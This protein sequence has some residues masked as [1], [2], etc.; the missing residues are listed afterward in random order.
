MYQLLYLYVRKT[1]S[2]VIKDEEE[3]G[4]NDPDFS[5]QQELA[6]RTGEISTCS[7]PIDE[8]ISSA[9]AILPK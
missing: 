5:P 1:R 8:N 3:N 7:T 6:E 4:P 2:R 9:I